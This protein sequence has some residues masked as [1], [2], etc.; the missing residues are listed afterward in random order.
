MNSCAQNSSVGPPPINNEWVL[1]QCGFHL[2]KVF[3]DFFV[4]VV[5]M[6]AKYTIGIHAT[7]DIAHEGRELPLH[8]Y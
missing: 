4:V 8:P 5:L 3:S 7:N 2:R 6:K 1:N